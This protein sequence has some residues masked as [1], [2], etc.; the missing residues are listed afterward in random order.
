MDIKDR[1]KVFLESCNKLED[2]MT[3]KTGEG[4]SVSLISKELGEPDP[5]EGFNFG[6]V[7]Y[8]EK[9]YYCVATN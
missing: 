1:A 6:T 3:F 8:Q 2:R 7:E 4:K 9:T 5:K